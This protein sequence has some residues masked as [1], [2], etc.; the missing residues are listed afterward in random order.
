MTIGGLGGFGIRGGGGG[1]D[2]SRDWTAWRDDPLFQQAMPECTQCY[3]PI[4]RF[5]Y[6]WSDIGVGDGPRWVRIA[7]VVCRAGHRV[8]VE[9]FDDYE[10]A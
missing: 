5:D 10:A 4:V 7:T 3:E 2:G 9:P 1:D 6:R 8:E